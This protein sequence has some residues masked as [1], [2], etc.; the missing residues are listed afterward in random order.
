MVKFPNFFFL[1]LV[2]HRKLSPVVSDVCKPEASQKEKRGEKDDPLYA[3][4]REQDITLLNGMHRD[5]LSPVFLYYSSHQLILTSLPFLFSFTICSLREVVLSFICFLVS[6][7]FLFLFPQSLY[8]L[9]SI[10]LLHLQQRSVNGPLRKS[11]FF[12]S[13]CKYLYCTCLNASI[14]CYES[15]LPPLHTTIKQYQVNVLPAN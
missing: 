7:Y 6:L 10:W 14:E 1:L 11:K 8:M 13:Y 2:C 4:E 3:C 15:L 5:L 9:L 12:L